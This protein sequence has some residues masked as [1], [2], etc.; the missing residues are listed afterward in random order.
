MVRSRNEGVRSDSQHV[1]AVAAG[2]GDASKR[3]EREKGVRRR[4][5]RTIRKWWKSGMSA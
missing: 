1:G 2:I 3:G 4:T 5:W